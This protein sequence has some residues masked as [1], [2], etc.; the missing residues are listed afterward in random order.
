MT[1]NI[2]IRFNISSDCPAEEG[3]ISGATTR[4]VTLIHNQTGAT[5]SCGTVNDEGD[6]WYNCTW[7]S[8]GQPEG[9]WSIN[10]TT[11]RSD[12]NQNETK[13]LN[14]FYLDNLGQAAEN[15][16]FAPSQ[17]GWGATYVYNISVYDPEG[18]TVECTL[19]TNTTGWINRGSDSEAGSGAGTTC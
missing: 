2:V 19:W 9:N 8:T 7:S 11:E 5:S 16:T 3:I 17:G 15:Q 4:V 12:Y 14:R 6:G 10:V 1:D 13:W 18:D